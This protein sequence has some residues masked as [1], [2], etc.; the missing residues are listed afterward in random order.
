MAKVAVVFLFLSELSSE[1]INYC[2]FFFDAA[3]LAFA[4]TASSDFF[5]IGN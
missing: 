3:S 1:E 4:T 2:T 5:G